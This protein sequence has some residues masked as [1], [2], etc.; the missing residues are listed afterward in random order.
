MTVERALRLIAGVFVTLSVLLGIY[1]NVNFLWFTL[2]VGVNLLQS[3]FTNW[4]PV[5]VI[6]RKGGLPDATHSATP[7]TSPR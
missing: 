4:C 3:A 5:M 1:V 7:V 2:F 6:L